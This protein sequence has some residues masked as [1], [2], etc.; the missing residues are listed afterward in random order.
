M[1]RIAVIG[2]GIIGA[3]V[4]YRLVQ[5]GARV[6]VID[7]SQPASGTTSASFAWV[8]AYGKSPYDYFELNYAGL[9]EHFRLANELTGKAPWLHLGGNL[10][11]AED[12]GALAGLRRRVDRMRSWGYA[13][14]WWEAWRVNEV[15]ESNVTFPSP[16]TP[17]AFFPEEF[18]VDAPQ[19]T[20]TLIELVR[21]DGGQTY[22]GTAVEAIETRAGRV[23]A[24]RFI[25]GDRLSV[26]GVVNAA[27]TE[28]DLLAAQLGRSLPL[29]P[30]KGLLV[31]L[32]VEGGTPL[33]RIVHPQQVNIRPDG[34]GR[35]LVH[36]ESIDE[37]LERGT[38]VEDSLCSELLERA[39]Q[40]V[41][42]LKSAEIAGFQVGVRSIPKDGRSCVGAVPTLPGYYEAV[43]HSGVTLGLIVGRLLAREILTG[44]V[45]TLIAPFRPDRFTGS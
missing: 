26:D 19:L 3:S 15:M 35:V 30:S 34:P 18:W 6:W 17:V 5:G 21:R 36:H 37:K 29:A 1:R 45:D 16:D 20:K 11:W 10:A 2:A 41:P 12:E 31:R 38:G 43:T 4:A 7:K 42:V 24:V 14:E 8:N 33:G 27:G 9:K 23:A 13:A 32:T 39:Q 28:A 22:L 40:V 25:G 44:E